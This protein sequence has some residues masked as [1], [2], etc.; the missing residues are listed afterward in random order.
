[1]LKSGKVFLFINKPMSR[2]RL[3]GG[4]IS[5]LLLKM[6]FGASIKF[7]GARAPVYPISS[8]LLEYSY[9]FLS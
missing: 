1:M 9:M 6:K 2:L 8:L 4:R 5:K 3:L 7:H